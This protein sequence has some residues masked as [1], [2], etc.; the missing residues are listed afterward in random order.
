M[1]Q[2]DIVLLTGGLTGLVGVITNLRYFGL[3]QALLFIAL[4]SLLVYFAHHNTTCYVTGGCIF[5]S[6]LSAVLA[7]F[8]F[9][10]IGIAYYYAVNK[11]MNAA[12]NKK[13]MEINPW[14][15]KTASYLESKYNYK[16]L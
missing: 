14:I 1:L 4:L 15:I 8:T 6:W 13:L 2:A 10:G 11:E 12:Y 7:L 3:K 16:L 9:S 5:S